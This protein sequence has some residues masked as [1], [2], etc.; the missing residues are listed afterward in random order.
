[1]QN[2]TI[3]F[4]TND[5]MLE[6]ACDSNYR[7]GDLVLVFEDEIEEVALVTDAKIFDEKSVSNYEKGKGKILN[8]IGDKEQEKLT[9][10]K[11]LA[12]EFLPICEDK[13]KKH[14]LSAMKLL[15]ADL[16]YDGKKLT[17]YFGAESRIDFRELA[18][19][20]AKTI[21]KM[22][23]LQ[24]IG[25]RDEAKIYGGYGRCGREVCCKSFLKNSKPITLD[26]ATSQ[27]LTPSANRIS[28]LCGKLMCCLSYEEKN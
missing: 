2:I 11:V 15:D 3:K 9:R 17:F 6:Y 13:I 20:L 8:K 18:A 16:S 25:S 21:K 10:L 26:M 1:M 19:D 27:D 23:R 28:G 24:Q 22:I 5:K 7:I 4:P 14:S 12:R